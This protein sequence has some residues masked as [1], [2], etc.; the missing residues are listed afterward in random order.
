M[1]IKRLIISYYIYQETNQFD[2]NDVTWV[3]NYVISP[4]NMILI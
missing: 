3:E 4:A 2:E 1:M